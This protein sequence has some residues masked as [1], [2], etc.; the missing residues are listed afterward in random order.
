MIQPPQETEVPPGA[1]MDRNSREHPFEIE[2]SDTQG[3]VRVAPA[4]VSSIVRVVLTAENRSAASISIAL[5]DQTTIHA[6]NRSHLGHDWPTDVISFILSETDDPILSG[7]LVISA[8]MAAETAGEFGVDPRDE[9]ALYIVHGLLH[10][11]GYDD[12][13]ETEAAVMRRR[14]GELLAAC[15]RPVPSRVPPGP[16]LKPDSC[17]RS[18]KVEAPADPSAL[19]SSSSHQ[20]EP[21]S[22]PR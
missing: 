2:L 4:E 7:E 19:L 3:H 20:P 12:Q 17:D 15:G 21:S 13:T 6:V 16:T 11:C 10:L 9:L 1:V 8:E 18:P 22:W 5:V 14:E